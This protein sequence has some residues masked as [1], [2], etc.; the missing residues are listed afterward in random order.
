MADAVGAEEHVKI[1]AVGYNVV[2]GTY[3]KDTAPEFIPQRAQGALE[4]TDGTYFKVLAQTAWVNGRGIAELGQGQEYLDDPFAFAHSENVEIID[5]RGELRSA[6][7]LE[8]T[9]V[10]LG[11]SPTEDT[12]GPW[13]VEVN[14]AV[15]FIVNQNE[16][17][18]T[19]SSALYRTT[20]NTFTAIK[21]WNHAW[22]VGVGVW[23]NR[24]AIAFSDRPT[25]AGKNEIWLINPVT[26]A[27]VVQLENVTKTGYSTVGDI[28]FTEFDEFLLCYVPDPNR[29]TG[30]N[31]NF[32]SVLFKFTY[33]ETAA[34]PVAASAQQYIDVASRSGYVNCMYTHNDII[35]MGTSDGHLYFSDSPP[36][37]V[38]VLTA[39]GRGA[40]VNFI[41][42]YQSGQLAIAVTT[43]TM[44]GGI[45]SPQSRKQIYL[46]NDTTGDLDQILNYEEIEDDGT[47]STGAFKWMFIHDKFIFIN[48][49]AYDGVLRYDGNSWVGLW[50]RG[51]SNK[52][53][54]GMSVS[55]SSTGEYLIYRETA[56]PDYDVF[57]T[58][59][60]QY[61]AT[62]ESSSEAAT[63]P[64]L[65]TSWLDSGLPSIDKIGVD[66]SLSCKPLTSGH[67][68]KVYYKKDQAT[69]YTLLGTF[70]TAG[71]TSYTVSFATGASTIKFKRIKFKFE[72]RLTVATNTSSPTIE[73][74]V[75]RYLLDPTDVKLWNFVVDAQNDQENVTI[76]I[77]DGKAIADA[78]WTL[79]TN[80]QIIDYIDVDGTSYKVYVL[81]VSEPKREINLNEGIEKQESQVNI[82]LLQI[83]QS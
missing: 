17:A 73:D 19:E 30:S 61:I 72:L 23:R 77:R 44:T 9:E 18:G 56:D 79:K 50:S 3:R 46:Y 80:K 5:K 57:E 4:L 42:S 25:G 38:Q 31:P 62:D 55:L 69:S 43:K 78:L 33:D 70:S 54:A 15:Y 45:Q 60:G 7:H 59:Q 16:G 40:F 64:Y 35:Y 13:I 66:F 76:D 51:N 36:T 24:L 41:D 37:E 49:H 14:K 81:D 29:D 58:V 34:V 27:D 20:G 2:R 12:H 48:W 21:T 71:G 75:M 53:P 10:G 8:R 67:S 52:S 11:N 63:V 32:K 74:F 83:P 82:R 26:G 39:F 6:E 68:I 47:H 1:N 65:E 22:I 28:L